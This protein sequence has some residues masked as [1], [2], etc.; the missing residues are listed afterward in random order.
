MQLQDLFQSYY[1]CRKNKRSTANALIFE[2]NYESNIIKLYNEIISRQYEIG[3][4]IAFIVN[5][6]VKREIFA[7][8]FRDR[9]VHHLIINKFNPIFEKKFIFDSYSCRENKWTLFWIRRIEKFIKQATLNY[10]KEAYILKL[11]IEGFFM[12]IDKNILFDLVGN[13]IN[14]HFTNEEREILIYLCTKIIYNN[15]T[16]NCIIK[17]ERQDWV[18]L[19]KTKSLFFSWENKGLP[20][21]N[22]TSQ[23]FANLYLHPLDE[24]I[25]KKLKIKYYWRYVDD[26]VLIYED[27]EYLIKA[28]HEIRTFLRDK[29]NLTLHPK[30]IYLQHYSKWVSFLWAFIKPYRIYAWTR[31]KTNFYKT[32]E[33]INLLINEKNHKLDYEDKKLILSKINSYLWLM[34]HYDTYTLRKKLLSWLNWYFWNYFYISDRYKLII[35]KTRVV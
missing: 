12:N 19:P 13:S 15:P 26:F 1:D 20:I 3:K 16:T 9:V 32:I 5:K 25:K 30:K 33:E 7:W 28:T 4:S 6:P 35:E 10:S 8:D 2:L 18:W 14:K 34:R 27:K 23:I 17:G 24:F 22:L 21:G 31:L 29:L 11:D